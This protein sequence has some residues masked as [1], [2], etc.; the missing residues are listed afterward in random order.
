MF[1]AISKEEEEEEEEEEENEEEED[2]KN[3]LSNVFLSFCSTPSIQW[4]LN[5][6]CR[7]FMLL[8]FGGFFRLFAD[9]TNYYQFIY[10]CQTFYV[11]III[12]CMHIFLLCRWVTAWV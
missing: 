12:I 6:K 8:F 11:G 3:K 5:Q 2:I 10:H 4:L 7:V 1:S 9:C